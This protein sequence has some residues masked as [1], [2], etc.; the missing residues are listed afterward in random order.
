MPKT[1]NEN[2]RRIIKEELQ[3]AALT[4]MTQYGI[5]KTTVDELVKRA[6]IPKGTFYLFYASKE[7]LLYEVIM[8]FHDQIQNEFIEKIKK[9]AENMSVDILTDAMYEISMETMKSGMYTIMANGE[10][11]TLMRKLPPEVIAEHMEKDEDMTA[12]LMEII[13]MTWGKDPDLYSTAFEGAFLIIMSKES[14]GDKFDEAFRIIIR[15]IVMQ[16]F[17]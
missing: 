6:K 2:E 11:E 13:P 5:K 8:K 15:G 7:M 3:K 4:C 10:M 17:E 16:F 14:L 12:R 1:Y 9:N